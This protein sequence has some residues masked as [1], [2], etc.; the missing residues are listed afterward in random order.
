MAQ[1]STLM[2]GGKETVI[3]ELEALAVF[4]GSTAMG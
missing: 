4:Y 3:G 1:L 2:E